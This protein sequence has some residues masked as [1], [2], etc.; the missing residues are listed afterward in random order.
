MITSNTGWRYANDS[1]E[2]EVE[3]DVLEPERVLHEPRLVEP[4]L[5]PHRLD[6]VGRDGR[7]LGH[8]RQEVAGR[9]VDEEER[10]QRDPHQQGESG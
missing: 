8:L 1:P 2:V 4:E 3:E 10:E 7:V 9:E 6:R 5:V